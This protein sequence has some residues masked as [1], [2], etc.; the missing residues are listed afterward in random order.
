LPLSLLSAL[1]QSLSFALP[2][3]WFDQWLTVLLLLVAFVV[4]AQQCAP[5]GHMATARP[6]FGLE[7]ANRSLLFFFG[8]FEAIMSVT[9]STFQ[10]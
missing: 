3:R 4:S 7:S 8:S 2:L 5:V 9:S 6:I 10:S 1:L